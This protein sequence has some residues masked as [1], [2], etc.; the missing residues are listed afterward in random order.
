[1]K[2]LK[3]HVITLIILLI[4][5]IT[6]FALSNHL[7]H[8]EAI[9]DEYNTCM[10]LANKATIPNIAERCGDLQNQTNSE[11]LCNSNHACWIE[12]K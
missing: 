3:Y 6:V 8:T 7:S 2:Y 4:G 9:Q 1:M 5:A 12:Q 10:E 11:F